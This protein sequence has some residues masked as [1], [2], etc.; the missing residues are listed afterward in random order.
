MKIAVP[1]ETWPDESRV[2]LVPNDVRRLSRLGAE[3]EVETGLGDAIGG[4]DVDYVSA[5]ASIATGR[6]AL[7]ASADLVL[8]VRKPPDEEVQWLKPGGVHISFLDPFN[9]SRLLH[10][11]A[12]RGVS[13]IS[14]EMMPRIT[15]TQKMDALSS[16]ASLAGHVAVILAA[17]HLPKIFPMMMTAAGLPALPVSG[18][19]SSPGRTRA[20]FSATRRPACRP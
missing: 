13:A 11:T 9:E 16:Q 6:Q 19:A 14:M 10:Q 18:T 17:R 20:S 8:R 7:V 15:R 3:V 4:V 2:A 5:G 1:M 12:G